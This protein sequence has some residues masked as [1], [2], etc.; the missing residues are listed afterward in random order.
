MVYYNG[1]SITDMFSNIKSDNVNLD[2]SETNTEGVAGLKTEQQ[3]VKIETAKRHVIS[4]NGI[5]LA[6]N[7]YGNTCTLRTR[8]L[9]S[10]PARSIAVFVTEY[11][12]NNYKAED[13]IKYILTING[14]DFEIVPINSQRNGIKIIKTS[15][16]DIN[17]EYVKYINSKISSAYLTINIKSLGAYESPHLANLKVLV[18]DKNV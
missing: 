1:S 5:E 12:P 7:E 17:T 8:N 9:T 3:L 4:I 2:L 16:L 15:S 6:K 14:E 13:Y 10:D 18:G 11:I